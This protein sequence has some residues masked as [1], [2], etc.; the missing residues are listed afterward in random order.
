MI[1]LFDFFSNT[2]NVLE[3]L[4]ESGIFDGKARLPGAQLSRL[5][6]VFLGVLVS[7]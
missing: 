3:L 1:F 4:C 2:Q 6:D 7:I 5:E